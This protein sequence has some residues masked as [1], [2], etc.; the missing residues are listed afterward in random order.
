M[1][2]LDRKKLEYNKKCDIVLMLSHDIQTRLGDVEASNQE[3]IQT[4][5]RMEKLL[6]KGTNNTSQMQLF[7]D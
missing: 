2:A 4:K 1:L 3:H 5:E 7:K 6:N